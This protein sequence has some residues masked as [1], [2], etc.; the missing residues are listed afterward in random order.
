MMA[1]RRRSGKRS[2]PHQPKSSDYKWFRTA[3][4]RERSFSHIPHLGDTQAVN[5]LSELQT[6]YSLTQLHQ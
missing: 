1:R 6:E 2:A 4:Q 3:M 5:S